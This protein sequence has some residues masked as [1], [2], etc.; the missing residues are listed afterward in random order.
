MNPFAAFQ[1]TLFAKVIGRAISA[2]LSGAGGFGKGVVK[3]YKAAKGRS[4][5]EAAIDAESLS[6]K[7]AQAVG[8]VF[9]GTARGVQELG[10]EIYESLA[11]IPFLQRTINREKFQAAGQRIQKEVGDELRK[12]PGATDSL[13]DLVTETVTEEADPQ[14]LGLQ[15]INRRIRP[16][17]AEISTTGV[18]VGGGLIGLGKGASNPSPPN[19]YDTPQGLPGVMSAPPMLA[20]A[21]ANNLMP[22]RANGLMPARANVDTM[23]SGGDIVLA[24]NAQR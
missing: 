8:T 12:I 6:G 1:N 7:A 10:G 3:G 11:S 16:A 22:A 18:F 13:W 5:A 20:P 9:G 2:P 15:S 14:K 24:M 21:R 19:M 17:V 4:L 23:G